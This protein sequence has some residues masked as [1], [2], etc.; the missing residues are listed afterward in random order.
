MSIAKV[1]EITVESERGFED[2]INQGIA[3]AAKTVR[4]IR[5]AWVKEQQVVVDKGKVVQYRV[6][7]KVTFILE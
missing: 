6:N 3:T 2:A 5:G 1:I 7:L 4:N